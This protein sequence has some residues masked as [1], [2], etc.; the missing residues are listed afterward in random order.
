MRSI[1]KCIE[2]YFKQNIAYKIC[3]IVNVFFTVSVS[4]S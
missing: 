1:V 4:L 3:E 2:I